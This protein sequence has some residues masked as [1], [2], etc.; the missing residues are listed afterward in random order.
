MKIANFFAELKRRN[1]YK[2]AIAYAVI[3]WLLIQAASILFPTFEA[4]GWVMK[5]FVALIAAGFPI[6][7]VLAWAF[8]LT[9]EGI[10]RTEEVSPHETMTRRTGRK[11]DFVIIG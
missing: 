4:P 9:P 8:E 2:V 5:V 11:I 1:V 10:K 6:A 3:A 7:L